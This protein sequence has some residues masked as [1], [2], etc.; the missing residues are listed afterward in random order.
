MLNLNARALPAFFKKVISN[1]IFKSISE[2]DKKAPVNAQTTRS[3][4]NLVRNYIAAGLLGLGLVSGSLLADA[5]F[6][7]EGSG[8]EQD[9]RIVVR[10][11]KVML[12]HSDQSNMS[13]IYDT[14]A[15]LFQV[16]NHREKTY[17]QL[18]E[19]FI[20][21]AMVGI[22]SM[23]PQLKAMAE[24]QGISE[25]QRE[26][27]DRI[28]AGAS[29]SPGSNTPVKTEVLA[30][31]KEKSV[32]G[33]T[34]AVYSVAVAS[35]SMQ[36]CTIDYSTVGLKKEDQKSLRELSGT[37]GN[38]TGGLQFH[39]AQQLAAVIGSLD[40]VVLEAI[41]SKGNEAIRLKQLTLTA[42]SSSDGEVPVDYSE[43]DIFSIF[44][45]L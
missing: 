10:N 14:V 31:G 13:L 23:L 18:S 4:Q 37:L 44:T 39:E 25:R 40:G 28:T 1:A 24:S 16:L 32:L 34:C 7:Y 43:T 36:V 20:Q 8:F 21:T 3:V 11:G 17:L 9:A 35:E 22:E 5:E 41:D 30:T 33:L 15:Q 38:L 2:A 26:L 6:V 29:D 12:T 19:E 42:R 27:L 45:G